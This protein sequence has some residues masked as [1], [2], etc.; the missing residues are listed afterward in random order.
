MKIG[1]VVVPA[2]NAAELAG[3][4]YTFVLHCG[5]GMYS[6]AIVASLEP[7]ALVSESGDMLWTA[8]V[9]PEYFTALCQADVAI[10]TRAIKRFKSG[11]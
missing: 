10:R 9:K 8:T 4:R 1:D 6:H 7:F 5:S 2:H 3:H 11:R